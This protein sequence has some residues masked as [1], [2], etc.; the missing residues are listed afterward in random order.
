MNAQII[1]VMILA[2]IPLQEVVGK[3]ILGLDGKN[4]IICG[5]VL[6]AILGIVSYCIP[7]T[8]A[9]LGIPVEGMGIGALII[10]G[11]IA[12]GGAQG[13][14]GTGARLLGKV[15]VEKTKK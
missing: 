12:S 15:G 11:L 14:W 7:S 9:S 3:I 6:G 13:L 2:L 4:M 8:I 1:G 5:F 10:D